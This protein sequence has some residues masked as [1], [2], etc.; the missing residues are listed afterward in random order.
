MIYIVVF[1][2]G[3]MLYACCHKEHYWLY[4]YP[5]AFL[6][7]NGVDIGIGA[8]IISDFIA[9]IAETACPL[10]APMRWAP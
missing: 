5:T 2:L 3:V 7:G 6:V 8:G 1:L 4:R 10:V 9:H